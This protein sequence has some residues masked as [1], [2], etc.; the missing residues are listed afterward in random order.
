MERYLIQFLFL[1]VS[2]KRDCTVFPQSHFFPIILSDATYYSQK[3]LIQY[4]C[5][6]NVNNVY[7]EVE[8]SH[9]VHFVGSP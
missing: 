2:V 3:I 6:N 1:G 5:N 7:S 9:L 8:Y 4:S